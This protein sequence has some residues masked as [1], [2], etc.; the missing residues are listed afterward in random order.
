MNGCGDYGT[1]IQLYLDGEL[2]GRDL[3]E[4]RAHLEECEVC[5]AELAAGQELTDLLH[6]RFL[7]RPL[8]PP[9]NAFENVF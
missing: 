8:M 9:P 3:E 2:S 6:R 7:L 1:T 4:F 5:Q